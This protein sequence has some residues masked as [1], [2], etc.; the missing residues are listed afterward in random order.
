MAF[1]PKI[2]FP[3]RGTNDYSEINKNSTAAHQKTVAIGS[4]AAAATRSDS[5]DKISRYSA[6]SPGALQCPAGAGG[7]EGG[8]V[9]HRAGAHLPG[10]KRR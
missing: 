7:A 8:D 9:G 4:S 3:G 10:R 1:P 6:P 2:V 5:P